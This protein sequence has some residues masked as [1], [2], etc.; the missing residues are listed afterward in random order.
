MPWA[1]FLLQTLFAPA[2]WAVPCIVAY[3]PPVVNNRVHERNC[4][5]LPEIVRYPPTS[6]KPS[7]YPQHLVLSSSDRF[8]AISRRFWSRFGGAIPNILWYRWG[9]RQ[10]W[11]ES[12]R[13]RAT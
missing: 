8:G 11:G 12:R 7:P 13:F 6:L 5:V 1:V 10:W 9:F 2:T 4:R 3:R